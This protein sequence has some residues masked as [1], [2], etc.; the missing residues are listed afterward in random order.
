VRALL[1]LAVMLLGGCNCGELT[2]VSDAGD[3][4]AADGG[5]PAGA[6]GGSA[7]CDVLAATIRDFRIDH[8]DFERNG[9]GAVDPGIVETMLGTDSKPVYA[10]ATVTP[11]TSGKANFDQWYRDVPGVNLRFPISLP[12]TSPSPGTYVFDSTAFFP[13]DDQGFGNEGNSHN[14][15]FTTEL[16]ATFSYRG[17]E[18][19]TFRG[20]DDVWIF[21]NHRLALDL[22]GLHP[23]LAGTIDFDARAAELG[24]TPGNSYALDAFHAERH[25]N[26]SNFRIETSI[27]CFVN[28]EIN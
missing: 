1:T 2:L 7:R 6:G 4:W 8:P 25:T 27:D 20:D 26:A 17:G 14:F 21:V 13:I 12:L 5:G 19:F 18:R 10:S 3:F 15:H 28:V 24:I 16:H 9:R 23:P 22:G 11:M